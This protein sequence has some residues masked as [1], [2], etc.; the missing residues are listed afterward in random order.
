MIPKSTAFVEGYLPKLLIDL[1]DY[2]F[3]YQIVFRKRGEPAS[4]IHNPA[5]AH[6][7]DHPFVIVADHQLR[8]NQ[9]PPVVAMEI[10]GEVTYLMACKDCNCCKCFQVIVCWE[11]FDRFVKQLKGFALVVYG[12]TSLCSS[13]LIF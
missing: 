7:M 12:L 1:P 8:D 10:F 9:F 5:E 6:H 11:A 13:V 2:Q 3:S 4:H